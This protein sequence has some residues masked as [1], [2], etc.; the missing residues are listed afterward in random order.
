MK[1][2]N[3]PPPIIRGPRVI[4]NSQYIFICTEYEFSLDGTLVSL[5]EVQPPKKVPLGKISKKLTNGMYKVPSPII[6]PFGKLISR[7]VG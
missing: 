1:I 3:S 4:Q 7:L 2:N 5:I 6:V